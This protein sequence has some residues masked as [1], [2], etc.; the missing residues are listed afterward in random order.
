MQGL[1]EQA[2][3][4]ARAAGTPVGIVGP[5][6]DMVRRFLGYGCTFAAVAS[7]VAL[8]TG[9]GGEWLAALRGEV[10]A[11]PAATAAY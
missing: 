6:P 8:M 4:A 11:R 10:A 7:D 9:R 5:N 1:I 3:S 2:A